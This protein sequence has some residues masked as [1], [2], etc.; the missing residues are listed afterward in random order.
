MRWTELAAALLL[1]AGPAGA[2]ELRQVG[3]YD[4]SVDDPEF[5]GMSGLVIQ[6]GGRTLWAVS[7]QGTLWRAPVVR[8]GTGRITGIGTPWHARFLD[9]AG[10]PVSRFTEDSEA[11]AAAP[12]GGFYIGYESYARVT[13]LHPPDMRPEPLHHWKRFKSLWNNEAFEGVARRADG[14]LLAVVEKRDDAAGGY[15]TYVGRG[16]VWSPGPVLRTA[17]GFGA[18]DATID[19]DGRLWLLERRLTWLAQFEV[20][21]STC[22]AADEGGVTCAPVMSAAPGILGNMEGIAL[23]RDADGGRF[24][25]LISDDN[26]N[27]FATTA[28]VEYEVLP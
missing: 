7:D 2:L 27:P 26:F 22:P 10:K 15:P 5:G 28:I 14:T 18:S 11:I 20:R 1:A 8:D 9:N 24:V 13:G 4:W 12:D 25:S 21:V 16:K 23:W 17:P 3:S 6:D 19:E